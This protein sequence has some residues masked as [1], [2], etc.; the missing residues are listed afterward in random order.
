MCTVTPSGSELVGWIINQIAHTLNAIQNGIA[1]GYTAT[2][3]SNNLIV[4]N[5]TMNDERNDTEYQCAIVTI[6]EG[7][8][9]TPPRTEAIQNSSEPT[10]LYVA[11]EY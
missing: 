11:G 10:I 8:G 9:N 4:Q 3:G 1:P 6:V 2:L 7:E 5:I